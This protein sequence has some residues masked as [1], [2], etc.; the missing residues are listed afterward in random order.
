MGIRAVL[1][2]QRRAEYLRGEST[3]ARFRVLARLDSPAD[4][5]ESD[6]RILRSAAVRIVDRN[7]R[8][9]RDEYLY[10]RLVAP[11]PRAT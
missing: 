4:S 6:P 5:M 7:E 8:Q 2:Y 9:L 3:P 1:N 10:I 11:R